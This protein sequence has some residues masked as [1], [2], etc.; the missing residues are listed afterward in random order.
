MRY[1]SAPKKCRL[2][3]TSK[4]RNEYLLENGFLSYLSSHTDRFR[5]YYFRAIVGITAPVLISTFFIT[6]WQ[7]YLVP[8]N[9]DAPFIVGPP[10]ASY[11]FF[12]WFV[13]GVLGL[14]LSLYGLNAV[15]AGM[16]MGKTSDGSVPR[17]LLAKDKHI[18]GTWS[19]PGGWAK[20]ANRLR[21]TG[22]LQMLPWKL[23]LAL[24]VPSLLVFI[25]LPISGLALETEPGYIRE[26]SDSVKGVNVTGYAYANFN[27]R[28]RGE[29]VSDAQT[30][31]ET[32]F[33]PRLPKMGL[34][35]SRPGA[36]M[37]P[38]GTLPIDRGVT[39]VFLTA[40][41]ETPIEGTAWGLAL[42]YDCSIVDRLS[43]FALLKRTTNDWTGAGMGPILAD[44]D[45]G[46]FITMSNSTASPAIGRF[47]VV[48][49][50]YKVWPD[51]SMLDKLSELE[52]WG[53]EIGTNCYFNQVAN[54]TGD[55]HDVD[56]ESI[57]EM[58]F[59]QLIIPSNLTET[60][61]YN[62]TIGHN[63]TDLYGA[64]S[65]RAGK[66]HWELIQDSEDNNTHAMTA[67]GIQCSSSAS[68]GTARVD[69][70]RSTFT[71]FVRTDTPI[72]GVKQCAPRLNA[73]TM[74]NLFMM[75]LPELNYIN[76]DDWMQSLV[77][78]NIP[79][80]RDF[81]SSNPGDGSQQ[82][83]RLSYLQ[84]EHLRKTVLRMYSSYA[85]HLM[86]GNQNGFLLS[87]SAKNSLNP[88]VTS[89]TAG[90]VLTTGPVP[91]GVPMALLLVW[92][93]TATLLCAIY[94]FRLRWSD[95]VDEGVRSYR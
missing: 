76:M 48:E 63:I 50:G 37:M 20:T 11:I 5:R 32:T 27:N 87:E 90:T 61:L 81:S 34:V 67:V 94:G 77:N 54:I 10:G 51:R 12:A 59:W 1:Q 42:N 18:S 78:G 36:E 47:G 69:G 33:A 93:L 70:V 60:P 13:V 55:Y 86:Y 84:A 58:A 92:T 21:Q 39:D 45:G 75:S 16:L 43:D 74:N 65:I 83:V 14:N 30:F 62:L 80:S 22:N 25:V 52:G 15:E 2:I 71:D 17:A 82:S 19:G 85:A 23:W 35:Y 57:F 3:T 28:A 26:L 66:S 88:N 24:A 73:E 31:W 7:V 68:V 91:A 9:P 79:P 89:F 41:A 72:A 38:Q 4:P 40:Q 8:L 46:T 56:Q 29:V 49:Y 64:Y 53:S 44:P 95:T 6:I